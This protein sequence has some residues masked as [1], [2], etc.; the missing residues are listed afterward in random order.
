M[1]NFICFGLLLFGLQSCYI[2]NAKRSENSELIIASDYLQPSDTILFASF[3]EK[4]KVRVKI[5]SIIRK[6][7]ELLAKNEPFNA[8]V[9]VLMF[10]NIYDT[11]K[12]SKSNMI[13]PIHHGI[14]YFSDTTLTSINSGII[15]LGYD[16]FVFC[17]NADSLGEIS[18]VG[19]VRSTRFRNHL[20]KAEQLI[21]LSGF[22][23]EYN[24]P[25]TMQFAIGMD[26]NGY[27]QDSLIVPWRTISLETYSE[28]KEEENYSFVDFGGIGM[29]NV[30]TAACFRQTSN[31]ELSKKF[32]KH[33]RNPKTNNHLNEVWNTIPLHFD[34]IDS[35]HEFK[36][37]SKKLDQFFQYYTI[38]ERMQGK[39]KKGK[40]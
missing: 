34:L 25:E 31:F 11:Y 17:Y 7:L 28:T 40:S 33:L 21:F 15:G 26:T 5:K 13:E 4:H 18:S 1:R 14:D 39:I 9:D 3:A 36:P 8:E 10:Q 30:R 12:L 32:L 22:R 24:S 29:F 38:I 6:E 20:S 19:E 2:E 27:Y 16:P 37:M 23:N 35:D